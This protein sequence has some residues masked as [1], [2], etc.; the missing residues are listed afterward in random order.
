MFIGWNEFGLYLD[1]A[2]TICV[3]DPFLF[4]LINFLSIQMHVAAKRAGKTA[5]HIDGSLQEFIYRHMPHAP[6]CT[7]WAFS[8]NLDSFSGIHEFSFWGSKRISR[9]DHQVTLF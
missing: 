3:N 6:A 1:L 4:K 7:L 5:P 9:V 2:V 8:S